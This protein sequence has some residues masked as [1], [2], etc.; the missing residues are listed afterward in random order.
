[1]VSLGN[2]LNADHP[3]QPTPHLDKIQKC[4]K[5][6]VTTPLSGIYEIQ[7]QNKFALWTPLKAIDMSYKG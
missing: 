6:K 3:M 5:Y 1:M 7:R 2:G 4:T